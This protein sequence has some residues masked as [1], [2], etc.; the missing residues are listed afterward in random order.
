MIARE[1][2]ADGTPHLHCLLRAPE[3]GRFDLRNARALDLDDGSKVCHGNIQA[4]RHPERV[5]YYIAKE[6]TR[7]YTN[8]RQSELVTLMNMGRSHFTS[9]KTTKKKPV[10]VPFT[11]RSVWITP[12]VILIIFII[13]NPTERAP[14]LAAALAAARRGARKRP[15]SDVEVVYCS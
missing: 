10:R 1:N 14:W 12:N 2:H 11:N 3:T 15:S 5:L 9:K 8:F 7:L 6:T 13:I 4:A